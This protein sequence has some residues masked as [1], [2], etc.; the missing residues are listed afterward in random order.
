M[1][2]SGRN[3]GPERCVL[4]GTE[5]TLRP[6]AREMALIDGA[7]DPLGAILVIGPHEDRE[8]RPDRLPEIGLD[9]LG[10]L[11]ALA[12]IVSRDRPDAA[13]VSLPMG[14]P[15][16][17]FEVRRLLRSLG[18]EERFVPWLEELLR[19]RAA[20]AR[21]ASHVEVSPARPLAPS[22]TTSFATLIERDDSEPGPIALVQPLANRIVVLE[23]ELL[24]GVG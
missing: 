6:L 5:R 2:T 8:R 24:G 9:V 16:T 11:D 23:E 3:P 10:G 12:E 18:V 7:P 20:P 22:P 21:S 13:V 19:S 1:S 14:M 17:I 15:G 4:I